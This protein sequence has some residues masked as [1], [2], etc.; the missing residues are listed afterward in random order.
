MGR[1][2]AIALGIGAAAAIAVVALGALLVLPGPAYVGPVVLPVS[3]GARF[4]EIARE[5]GRLGIVRSPALLRLWARVTGRDRGVAWGDYLLQPP[6]TPAAVLD[7]LAAGPDPVGRV[8]IPEG[9]TVAE[10]IAILAERGRGERA[11]FEALLADRSFLAAHGVPA[12]GAEGYLFPD[13][14]VFPST[15]SPEG[16]LA[17]ML[18]RFREQFAG[19]VGDRTPPGGLTPHQIVTLA[20]LIEEET[21]RPEEQRLVSAVFHNRLRR[22]MRLQS[23]PT[24]LYGRDGEG[25]Q[26]T[27]TDLARQTAYNTYV[28]AGLPPTPIANPGRSALAAAVSPAPG[29][30]LYFVA[31]GDGSHAFSAT[32][33]EHNAAVARYREALRLSSESPAASAAR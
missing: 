29:D 24:V 19:A 22:G 8:T 1:I 23:D 11:R 6:L 3:E 32:L 13:T 2:R 26:I 9:L 17:E 15:M 14:Y 16:I 18:D 4:E 5:L 31:Q 10:T 20:S 28:I 27:R 21:T 33:A 12:A 30:A 7:R 25:R